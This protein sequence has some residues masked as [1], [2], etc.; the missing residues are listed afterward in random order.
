MYVQEKNVKYSDKDKIMNYS[1]AIYYNKDGQKIYFI[2]DIMFYLIAAF[3]FGYS[4]MND[5]DETIQN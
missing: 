2:I 4:S 3:Y 1:A 5:I